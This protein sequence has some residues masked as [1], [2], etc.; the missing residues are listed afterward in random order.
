MFTTLQK[1]APDPGE[2]Y[3]ELSDR[4]N[5]V[6]IADEAHRS[7]YGHYARA[8]KT[9]EISYGFSKHQRD[10]LSKASYMGFTGTPISKPALRRPRHWYANGVTSQSLGLPAGA[11]RTPAT[12]GSRRRNAFYP[13]GVASIAHQA[14]P[15]G[16]GRDTTA[17]R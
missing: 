15:G 17:L 6:V 10:A 12:P 8:R 2:T 14:G 7:Q 4:R 3:P 13:I 11:P 9:G 5:F 1:F 16:H